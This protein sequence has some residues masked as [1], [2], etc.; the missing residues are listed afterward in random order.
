MANDLTLSGIDPES[1]YTIY[2][3]GS[4]L[5]DDTD[6]NWLYGTFATMK[7]AT[8]DSL[9]DPITLEATIYNPNVVKITS[10][11]ISC[12]QYELL[13]SG[14]ASGECIII[15]NLIKEG[16][17]DNFVEAE[18]PSGLIMTGAS[19]IQMHIVAS[20]SIYN[21]D[22]GYK[23]GVWIN[24]E[25][26]T[27]ETNTIGIAPA[28][29]GGGL[30]V[31]CD[32]NDRRN[33]NLVLDN[34]RIYKSNCSDLQAFNL[35]QNSS[36]YLPTKLPILASGVDI[37]TTLAQDGQALFCT[38]T[39][40]NNLYLYIYDGNRNK[41]YRHGTGLKPGNPPGWT[42]SHVEGK[43]ADPPSYYEQVTDVLMT[44]IFS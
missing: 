27:S 34:V 22:G 28:T 5:F 32:I 15:F 41:W 24:G 12:S 1:V 43:G 11:I 9:L 8:R 26:I 31:A 30:Y 35:Y 37:T 2:G 29:A 14:A 33:D 38:E 25:L 3:S 44:Q 23:S 21:S 19:G 40:F 10:P 20:H 13:Y 17:T 36:H 4:A 6:D 18:V 16:G 39:V 7:N 42:G